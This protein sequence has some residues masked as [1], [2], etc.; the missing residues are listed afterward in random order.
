MT[1]RRYTQMFVLLTKHTVLLEAAGYLSVVTIGRPLVVTIVSILVRV[2]GFLSVLLVAVPP[3]SSMPLTGSIVTCPPPSAVP[4][5]ELSVILQPTITTKKEYFYTSLLRQHMTN[6]S[7]CIRFLN[8][9][10]SKQESIS[11]GV[12]LIFTR[13]HINLVVAFKGPK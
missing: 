8:W 6:L 2:V 4:T 9:V 7:C 13:G 10:L 12:N 3:G 5:S 1:H 11:R